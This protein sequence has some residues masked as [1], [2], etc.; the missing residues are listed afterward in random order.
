MRFLF[1]ILLLAGC[2]EELNLRIDKN[3]TI[4]QS[5]DIISAVE[6]WN[7]A[8]DGCRDDHGIEL[9]GYVEITDYDSVDDDSTRDRGDDDDWVVCVPPGDPLEDKYPDSVNGMSTHAANVIIFSGKIDR[10]FFRRIVL[11]E[12]GHYIGL[13]HSKNPNDV[14]FDKGEKVEHLS[15]GDI[16]TMCNME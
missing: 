10:E 9:T 1:L 11:H 13:D 16:M 8:W 15:Y 4:Q 2:N 3:C 5:A 14:M 12:I 7:N 6:E